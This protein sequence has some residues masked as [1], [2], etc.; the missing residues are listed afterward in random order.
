MNP[1][2]WPNPW[3]D[4]VYVPLEELAEVAQGIGER[5]SDLQGSPFIMT[6]EMMLE[7]WR[8]AGDKLDAYILPCPS[9]YHCIGIR[10]GAEGPQYLSPAGNT[11]KVTALLQKYTSRKK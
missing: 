7:H 4:V 2:H 3:S 6:T 8:Q 1:P 5:W 11:E 10:Y 9:G